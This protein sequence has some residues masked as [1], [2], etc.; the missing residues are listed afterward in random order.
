MLFNKLATLHY[1]CNTAIQ[2]YYCLAETEIFKEQNSF[3]KRVLRRGKQV[4]IFWP[5]IGWGSHWRD[6]L[7]ATAR[8]CI[9][10]QSNWG[11]F[12]QHSNEVPFL[13]VYSPLTQARR[14]ETAV[15]NMEKLNELIFEMGSNNPRASYSSTVADGIG[16]DMLYIL[17]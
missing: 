3:K 17:F 5:L 15:V 13:C 10:N 7:L 12:S 4:T 8:L 2:R 16:Q 11:H 9:V 14:W 6:K 1:C